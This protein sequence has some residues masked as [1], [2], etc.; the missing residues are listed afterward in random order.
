MSLTLLTR[1]CRKSGRLFSDPLRR[2]MPF[3]S[4]ISWIGDVCPTTLK[5]QH[6][7]YVCVCV[8]EIQCISVGVCFLRG[9]ILPVQQAC[10]TSPVP[11]GPFFVVAR[12]CVCVCVCVCV[13]LCVFVR[14]CLRMSVYELVIRVVLKSWGLR[15]SPRL[16]SQRRRLWKSGAN[17]PVR[18]FFKLCLYRCCFAFGHVSNHFEIQNTFR[19]KNLEDDYEAEK[20][21]S[22]YASGSPVCAGK[23]SLCGRCLW[24]PS[25]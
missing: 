7:A 3:R 14:V 5:D 23:H 6:C 16:L 18:F 11:K 15:H 8:S 19:C 13:C 17:V 21:N 4:F 10:F 1:K 24:I 25:G 20:L 12:M 2:R 9:A 22:V